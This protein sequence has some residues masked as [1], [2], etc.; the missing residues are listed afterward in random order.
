MDEKLL[1]ILAY[2]IILCAVLNSFIVYGVLQTLLKIV[3]KEEIHR[4]WGVAINYIC[5]F[6]FGFIWN[7][8]DTWYSNLFIGFIIGNTSTALYKAAINSLLQVIPA[9]ID[10]LLGVSQRN[11]NE[12]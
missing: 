3:N 10:K 12:E 8:A 7:M 6:V 1:T 11:K 5:S 9:L 2:N 4:F